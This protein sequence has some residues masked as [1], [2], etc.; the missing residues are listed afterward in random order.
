M[1]AQVFLEAL[2]EPAFLLTVH[3]QVVAERPWND[4]VEVAV[5]QAH[6]AA[7]AEG[8][9]EHEHE[10]DVF[11]PARHGRILAKAWLLQLFFI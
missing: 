4:H 6:A 7:R 3:V 2:V 8:E 1:P 9:A 5:G 10:G 11:E